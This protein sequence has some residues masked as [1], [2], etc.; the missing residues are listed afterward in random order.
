MDE[1]CALALQSTDQ[2]RAGTREATGLVCSAE[3]RDAPVQT[4][5]PS[6]C[7]H[8]GELQL[9]ASAGSAAASPQTS[10]AS[11]VTFA[12]MRSRAY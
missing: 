7:R 2:R 8:G 11:M 3:R 6:T 9:R 4:L 5:H 1:P 10:S 12:S